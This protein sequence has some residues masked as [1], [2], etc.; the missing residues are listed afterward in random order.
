MPDRVV[1]W[2][3]ADAEL[4]S[5]PLDLLYTVGVN[6]YRGERSL[7]LS[8]VAVRAALVESV[9]EQPGAAISY[10][11][12]D[13]RSELGAL[14]DLPTAPTACWYA[15]GTKLEAAGQP[16]AYAPRTSL[17]PCPTLVLWSL[18]PAPELWQHLL[19]TVQPTTLYLCGRE[20]SDDTLPAVIRQVGAM[21]KFALERDQLIQVDR[22]AARLCTTEAVI[23]HSLLWLENRG[24]IRLE[25]W[26]AGDVAQIAAGTGQRHEETAAQLRAELEEQLAEVRAYRRF[27]QRAKANELG[28]AP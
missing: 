4:P 10:K 8:L 7:Q 9:A 13:W 20:S 15:E 12:Y 1:W 5:G 19:T 3:G 23:R 28:I 16:I 21:C 11:L 27:F 25:R 14:H 24:H 17:A 18:P 6:E 22:M 26:L 2:N